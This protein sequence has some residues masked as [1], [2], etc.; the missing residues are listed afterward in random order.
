MFLKYGKSI[1]RFFAQKFRSFT[2]KFQILN[3]FQNTI[4]FEFLTVKLD[5]VIF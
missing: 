5:V 3:K 2:K 4:R 1:V